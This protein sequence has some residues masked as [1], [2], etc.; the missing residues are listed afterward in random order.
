V[1]PVMTD[2]VSWTAATSDVG[3]GENR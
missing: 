1:E 2:I 3:G